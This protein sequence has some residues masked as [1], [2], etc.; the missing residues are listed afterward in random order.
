ME[1]RLVNDLTAHIEVQ[2]IKVHI[3]PFSNLYRFPRP[4]RTFGMEVGQSDQLYLIIIFMHYYM[5]M[6]AGNK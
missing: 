4:L 2:L 5:A 3:F 6:Y 1:D